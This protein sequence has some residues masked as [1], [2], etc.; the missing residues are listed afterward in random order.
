[1]ADYDD[2]CRGKSR[3]TKCPTEESR[4]SS[5]LAISRRE[6]ASGSRRHSRQSSKNLAKTCKSGSHKPVAP[7]SRIHASGT[8]KE[9][10]ASCQANKGAVVPTGRFFEGPTVQC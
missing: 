10:R 2:G 4:T 7:R 8:K 9:H 1:M 6:N 5:S 3:S